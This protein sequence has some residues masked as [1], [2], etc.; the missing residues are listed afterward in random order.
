M[1]G[2]LLK[3]GVSMALMA[4]VYYIFI[5]V[6][7]KTYVAMNALGTFLATI[8]RMSSVYSLEEYKD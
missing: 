4:M 1:R 3:E 2:E 8:D 7:M 6:N 5:S